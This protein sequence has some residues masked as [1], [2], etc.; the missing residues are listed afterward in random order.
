MFVLK[1]LAG[2]SSR[3]HATGNYTHSAAISEHV[4]RGSWTQMLHQSPRGETMTGG[5]SG[6]HLWNEASVGVVYEIAAATSAQAGDPAS[7]CIFKRAAHLSLRAV[8]RWLSQNATGSSPTAGRGQVVKN[9]Y[10]PELR[11]GYEQYRCVQPIRL[12]WRMRVG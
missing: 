1:Y 7:A 11:F 5:R 10:P 8:T 4:R 9:W 3:G 2:M 12:G 6:Q